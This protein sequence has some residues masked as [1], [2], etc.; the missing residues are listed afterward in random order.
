MVARAATGTMSFLFNGGGEGM[1]ISSDGGVILSVD[2]V[3]GAAGS[4]LLVGM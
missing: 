4:V 1:L 3:D 2:L